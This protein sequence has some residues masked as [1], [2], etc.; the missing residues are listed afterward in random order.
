[1]IIKNRKISATKEV[2]G[3][4]P[5]T[6]HELESLL[7]LVENE[8]IMLRQHN[9]D[10][11]NFEVEMAFWERIGN[12]IFAHIEQMRRGLELK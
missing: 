5:L 8:R 6:L 11:P 12:S 2:Y 4:M 1:M 10:H 3:A 7:T 9:G